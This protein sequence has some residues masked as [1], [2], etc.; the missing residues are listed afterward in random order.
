[1][2]PETRR[3]KK[4]GEDERKEDKNEKQ[5]NS[6]SIFRFSCGRTSQNAAS[7]WILMRLDFWSLCY[8]KW[9]KKRCNLSTAFHKLYQNLFLNYLIAMYRTKKATA[10]YEQ[11]IKIT[12]IYPP[13][14]DIHTSAYFESLK[15]R[16]KVIQTN[17]FQDIRQKLYRCGHGEFCWHI[18]ATPCVS[19]TILLFAVHSMLQQS[20]I[21]IT[22][23]TESNL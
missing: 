14:W 10:N 17:S 23:L 5:R 20:E 2:K 3:E 9:K 8:N 19:V 7:P 4:K 22:S 1:M 11:K 6:S 18:L 16:I 13:K 12:S 21:K 15:S